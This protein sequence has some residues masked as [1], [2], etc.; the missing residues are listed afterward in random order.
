MN[1][2]AKG[3]EGQD[4]VELAVRKA[5][6]FQCEVIG[7][8]NTP[9]AMDIRATTADGANLLVEVKHERRV[10]ADDVKKFWADVQTAKAGA[11]VDMAL[12]VSIATH[13]PHHRNGQVEYVSLENGM[14]VPIMF[15]AN[16][17][18]GMRLTSDRVEQAIV[19]LH[20]LQQLCKESHIKDGEMPIGEELE[21]RRKDQ[22]IL[23]AELP[24][25]FD[26]I[27][28]M[29]AGWRMQLQAAE[30]MQRRASE[31]L[32][33][34]QRLRHSRQRMENEFEWMHAT[35]SVSDVRLTQAIGIVREYRTKHG[36]FP[37]LEQLAE[38][39]E[40]DAQLV[41]AAGGITKVKGLIRNKR[42][43]SNSLEGDIDE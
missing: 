16:D 25:V 2:T 42:V 36:R 23:R 10:T 4:F 38:T 37:T 18:G 7:V 24:F 26:S 34:L 27:N 41:R 21:Q 31:E 20:Q 14:R 43:A 40:I 9:H 35:D 39:S 3:L 19:S 8:N 6:N 33:R 22:L 32:S 15:L 13:I 17:T 12:M 11:M 5:F 28:N 1:T 30:T 29:E